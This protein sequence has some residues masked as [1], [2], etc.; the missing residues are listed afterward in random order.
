MVKSNSWESWSKS[1]AP[2][3]LL[4]S[5]PTLSSILLPL[6][7]RNDFPHVTGEEII[8]E[9]LSIHHVA[10]RVYGTLG[11]TAGP[12]CTLLPT[13]AFEDKKRNNI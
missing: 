9:K 4:G 7:G 6:E 10:Q 11:L 1:Q 12:V 8:L 5:F 13:M 2:S 3:T